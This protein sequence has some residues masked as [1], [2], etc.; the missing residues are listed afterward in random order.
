MKRL[1]AIAAV[2]ALL[3][4]IAAPAHAGGYGNVGVGNFGAA[5]GGYGTSFSQTTTTYSQ[6]QVAPAFAAPMG[7]GGGF[8]AAAGCAPAFGAPV[9]YGASFAAPMGYGGGFRGVN[10]FGSVGVFGAGNGVTLGQ[11]GGTGRGKFKQRSGIFGT[12]TVQKLR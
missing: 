12:R 1:I 5:P 4:L 2:L 10:N 11:V 3:A 6:Q 8:G 9:G 7:Y